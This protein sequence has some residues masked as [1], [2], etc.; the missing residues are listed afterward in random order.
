MNAVARTLVAILIAGSL[1]CSSGA[2]PPDL[3]ATIRQA[4]STP[5]PAVRLSELHYDNAGADVGEAIEVSGPAGTDVTGWQVVLYNGNGGA[6][7]NTRPLSGTIPVTCGGRGVLVLTYPSNGIQNGGATATGTADADGMALVD[8]GGTVVEFL[9]YEGTFTASNGPAVDLTSVDIGVRELG[10]EAA[11]QSLQRDGAGA[12]AAPAPSTFGACN[13]EA[14]LPPPPPEVATVTITPAA[15]SPAVGG[16]QLFVATAFDA[17]GQP[18]VL[19]GSS[20]TWTTSGPSVA[21]V[22]G[23]GLCT[24]LAA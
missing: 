1:S 16:T 2:P 17:A 22:D 5:L 21:T 14:D 23:N 10:T 13:D 9:S 20:F 7:Y 15:A 3:T 18:I 4:L 11:G 12:W 8:A 19:P 6:S 24:A